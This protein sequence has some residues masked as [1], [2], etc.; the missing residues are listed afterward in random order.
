MGVPNRCCGGSVTLLYKFTGKSL[1]EEHATIM[2]NPIFDPREAAAYYDGEAISR[3]YQQCWGG[4]DIHIG[5]YP[6]GSETVADASADMT[7][8][9]LECAGIDEGQR[10]LDIACGYGGTLR[11]LAKMGCQVKGLDIS[12]T[13]V[14]YAQQANAEAGLDDRI[15]VAVGDFHDIDSDDDSW[16]AVV[17]QEAIIHSD[18]RPRVFSEVVR[19][20]RPGG[21]FAL[22]D[23]VTGENA[24]I[25]MV[26]AAFARLGAGAGATSNSY[27][28]MAREAGLDIVHAEERLGDIRTHYD[29]LAAML[30]RPID[31][32]DAD[33][34][35]AISQSVSRWQAALAGGHISWACFVARKPAPAISE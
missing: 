3:F 16:D 23:I 20:L 28:Q 29:K 25:P 18:N 22:S 9:L 30:A 7:R 2:S 34:I 33:A 32:L 4:E 15:E 21:I 14:D 11:T 10:V 35:E 6:T 5:R 17:C 12:Q 8:H 27:Q 19:V 31:G 26:E 1:P 13:C 24:D